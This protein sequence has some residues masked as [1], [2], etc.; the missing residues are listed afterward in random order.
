MLS[1]MTGNNTYYPNL[2]YIPSADYLLN[3]SFSNLALKNISFSIVWKD[4]N[5]VSHKIFVPKYSSSSVK[6]M[7]KKK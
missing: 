4:R 7:F 6:L 2:T 5:N 1:S 3:D